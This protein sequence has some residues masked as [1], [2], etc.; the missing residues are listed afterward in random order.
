[1]FRDME[2][3]ACFVAG[4]LLLT[5]SLTSTVFAI[6]YVFDVDVPAYFRKIAGVLSLLMIFP[7]GVFGGLSLWDYLERLSED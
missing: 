1:M 7:F 5:G 6:H 2:H 4:V 3:I